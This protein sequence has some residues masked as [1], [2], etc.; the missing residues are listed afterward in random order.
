MIWNDFIGHYCGCY[1]L[2]LN[3]ALNGERLSGQRLIE[4]KILTYIIRLYFNVSYS[5]LSK[6]LG[7]HKASCQRF[8]S[9]VLLTPIYRNEADER[10]KRCSEHLN[11]WMK[12]SG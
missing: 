2:D 8:Y 12:Q 7:I 1:N 11:E 10:Y 5:I 6:K 4:I 3:P 9:D